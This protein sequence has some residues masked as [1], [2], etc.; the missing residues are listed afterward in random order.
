MHNLMSTFD[1]SDFDRVIFLSGETRD[2]SNMF[3]LNF[4]L[5]SLL[6][7]HHSPCTPLDVY[8][9]SK[10]HFDSYLQQLQPKFACVG[11]RC[12]SIVS[13]VSRHSVVKKLSL[14]LKNSYPACFFFGLVSVRG[15]IPCV[16]RTDLYK[17]ILSF[18]LGNISSPSCRFPV[19]TSNLPLKSLSRFFFGRPL[20][21]LP[22][23]PFWLLPFL[24]LFVSSQFLK[25]LY[26]FLNPIVYRSYF[27]DLS[28]D[29]ADY[30]ID[31]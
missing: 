22:S 17:A 24:L 4:Q 7:D 29:P 26:L 11:I 2:V 25:K 1:L 31:F 12:G 13:P 18:S 21:Y 14:I 10:L 6:V 8:G 15:S 28:S 27:S 9:R 23:I 16:L 3:K 20:F 30:I 5:P 19:C